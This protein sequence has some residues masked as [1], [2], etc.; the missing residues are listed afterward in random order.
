[1]ETGVG[2]RTLFLL[3]GLV[4]AL[5]LPFLN[6]A[7]QGD[8]DTYLKEAAHALIEP[9]HPARTQYVFRGEP[10]DLRGHPHPPLNAWILAGLIAATGGVKE[11]PF[12]AAYILFSLVAVWAMW[13][14]ARRFSERPVWAVLLFLAVPAFVVN[15][16][17]FETDL[18]FLAFWIAAVALFVSG[19]LAAAALAMAAA[20]MT[21][22]QAIFLVPILAVYTWLFR[23][24]DRA[25]WA[26]LFTP[27][28]V[29]AGWQ[30]F[31][32]TTTGAAPATVLTGYF[33]KYGFQA[34]EVKL[35]NALM[36][37]IHSWFI[38]F[39]LLAVGAAALAWKKRAEPSTQFLIAWVALFFTGAV[40]VFF[41]GSARYLLPMAAPVALLA[42]RLN[43]RWLAPAFA[44]QMALSLGLAAENYQHWDAYRKFAEGK[45]RMWVNGEWGLRHY[46]EDAGALP[47]EKTTELR[48]GDVI[49]TS[50]LGRAVDVTARTAAIRTAEI[51]PWIPLRI[52][53]LESHSGYSTVSAGFW[54]FGISKG[55]VD[56]LRLDQVVE[57]HVTLEYLPMNAP[58]AADQ[59]LTGIYGLDD[60][61]FRWMGRSGTVLLKPPAAPTPLR[62][63]LYVP[64]EA[65]ARRVTLRLDGREVASE[66]YP[67]PGGYSLVTAAETGRSLTIEVDQTF[68]APGDSRELGVVL[69][70]A[71]FRP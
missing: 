59:I 9:L 21:A 67:G 26:T 66:T 48:G 1:M 20:S 7:V 16:T 31:E 37:F 22:Y 27:P 28:A 2:R 62:V 70:G 63:D 5:R 3:L 18:P 24:G 14:L 44:I 68:F 50:E 57:R 46:L 11:A 13:V 64:P 12:H 55:V 19:R 60:N 8:D 58:E 47:L 38:V 32:R 40:A 71:G 56:R 4:L 17:S 30:I 33:S 36:L 69:T 61:R 39:P 52:L 51:R 23:R 65:P 15:G 29:I 49:I 41:A 42:S 10:V 45:P 53:G 54:P 25:S 43:A 6:Q 34:I 35:A